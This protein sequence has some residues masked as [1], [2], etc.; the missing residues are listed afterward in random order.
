M[1]TWDNAFFFSMR[2]DLVDPQKEIEIAEVP[3]IILRSIDVGP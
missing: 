1:H 3:W 2:K